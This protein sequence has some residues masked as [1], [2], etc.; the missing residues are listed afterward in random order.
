MTML[1]AYH[2]VDDRDHWLASPKREEVF[3]PLGITIKT[4]IDPENPA[5]AGLLADVPDMDAF[6][7][8]MSSQEGADAMAHDG[9]RADTLVLLVEA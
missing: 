3:G 5:R 1:I 8:L 4:F 2:E 9:V 6:Q 7:A